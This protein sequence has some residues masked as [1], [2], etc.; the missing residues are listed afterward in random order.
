VGCEY[1]TRHPS[2]KKWLGAAMK[3]AS[4]VWRSRKSGETLQEMTDRASY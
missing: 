3:I 1:H 4:K 2:I